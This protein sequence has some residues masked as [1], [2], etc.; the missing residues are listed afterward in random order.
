MGYVVL[1]PEQKLKFM[2]AKRERYLRFSLPRAEMEMIEVVWYGLIERRQGGVDQQVM[3]PSVGLGHARRCNSHVQKAEMYDRV[4]RKIR[5]ITQSDEINARAFGRRRPF[6]TRC[7]GR[8]P[9]NHNMDERGHDRRR[10]R[11]MIFVS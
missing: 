1:V 4:G 8:S 5:A 10:V 2:R 6:I 11:D 7:W 3:M 9:G